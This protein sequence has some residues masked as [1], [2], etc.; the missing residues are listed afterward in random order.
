MKD[1][2][3]ATLVGERELAISRLL[4]APRE[5]VWSVWTDP[6]HIGEWWGPNGF[7]TTTEVMDLR[8]GGQW[9]FVMHGPDGRDYR[10][11][12][13][14]LEVVRPERL[15]YEHD[16]EDGDEPV[17]FHVTVTFAEEAGRT[18][19]TMRMVFPSPDARTHVVETYGA[20]D[21]LTQ[22]VGRLEEYLRRR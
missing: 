8:P 2:S 1:M 7:R 9:R 5:L 16:G 22:T 19:L 4:D 17:N 11:R 12:I 20:A 21:G 6:K 13:V 15:V 10:N 14:Y 18:R 3:Q